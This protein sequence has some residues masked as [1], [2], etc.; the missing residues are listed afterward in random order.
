[1]RTRNHCLEKGTHSPPDNDERPPRQWLLL[2][3]PRMPKRRPQ[4]PSS[5]SH[6][7]WVSTESFALCC[8]SAHPPACLQRTK[9]EASNWELTY[10]K[11]LA[12]ELKQENGGQGGC[13]RK[14]M[15]SHISDPASSAVPAPSPEIADRILIARLSLDTEGDVMSDDSDL[16]A[17]LAGLPKGQ[18]S[19][20]YLVGAWKRCRAQES[21]ARKVRQECR[22]SVA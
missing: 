4:S 13:C 21:R 6:S 20:D 18:T 19:Y 5:T 8:R 10:L 16:L 14:C 11:E 22:G 2:F 3:P 9:A 7:T 17:V 15:S 12:E 1:M